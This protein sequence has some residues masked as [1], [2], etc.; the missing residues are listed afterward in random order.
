M[1]T[2]FYF[3]A[4]AALALGFASCSSDE[5]INGPVDP[6]GP[7][8][9]ESYMAVVI[10]NVGS[11]GRAALP[12]EDDFEDPA[13]GSTESSFTADNIC[14]YFFTAAGQPFIMLNQGVN[15]TVSHTNMVKPTQIQTSNDDG[16]GQTIK[17]I[18]VLGAPEKY[19][20]N[21]PA[22]VFCVA[23]PI[24]HKFED[25]ANITLNQIKQIAVTYDPD[26]NPFGK[27]VMTS[28][29][30]ASSNAADAEEIFYTD[31]TDC[32]KTTATEAEDNPAKI[33]L[34]RLAAK[35]RVKGLGTKVVREKGE[36]TTNPEAEFDI[37]G[38]DGKVKLDVELAGWELVK[39]AKKLCCQKHQ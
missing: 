34:E 6:A 17:G 36:G 31:V 8:T 20:G 32:I 5:P 7:T 21:K 3:G 30:Y 11:N 18:L 16:V 24:V 39:N 14:F 15:G 37:T 33:F 35:V 26:K 27:F 4:F 10:Q 23:N 1:K 12:G 19:L 25:F 29:S 9:G 13:A 28:S 38:I 22:K 2:K